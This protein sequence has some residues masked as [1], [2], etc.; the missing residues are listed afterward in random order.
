[1]IPVAEVTSLEIRQMCAAMRE[2]V[3]ADLQE[4]TEPAARQE[5][6]LAALYDLSRS[7]LPVLGAPG[8]SREYQEQQ[9]AVGELISFVTIPLIRTGGQ[10]RCVAVLSEIAEGCGD[11]HLKKKLS[12]YAQ[13]L[14]AKSGNGGRPPHDGRNL[15][16][17]AASCSALAYG[18]YSLVQP[19]QEQS[20]ATG[21]NPQ[22]E[23]IATR[24]S[25]P[26]HPSPNPSVAPAVPPQGEAVQQ[27]SGGGA[28]GELDPMQAEG[29]PPMVPGELVTRVNF[30]GNQ[31]LVPVTLKNGDE[32]VRVELVLDTGATRTAIHEAVAAKLGIDLHSTKASLSEVADGRTISSRTA[33]ID[34]IA[35]GPFAMTS[36]DIELIPYRGDGIHAG[37][38]GMDFLA[39]HRYQIDTEHELIRWF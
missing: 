9:A 20:E 6:L 26:H 7:I 10:G 18:M 36:A 31:V 23:I 32:M 14:R 12:V 24:S 22:R 34:S 19:S 17:I 3:T 33:R 29:R 30:V 8:Y 4:A 11:P 2:K 35:V 25:P 15:L 16:L 21:K 37:L 1:M 38:L 27:D 39:K 13:E 5:L 28:L